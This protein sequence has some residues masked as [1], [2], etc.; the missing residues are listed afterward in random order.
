MDTTIRN[1][2]PET[3]R[4]LKA[5]A[6]SEGK[7][8]GEAVNEAMQVYLAHPGQTR[9]RGSLRDLTPEEYSR[10]S[11]RL[12]EEV[13]QIVYF[14]R[15]AAVRAAEEAL[16]ESTLLHMSPTG[17]NAFMKVLSGPATPVR[18][19]VEVLERAAPWESGGRR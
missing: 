1:L 5:R 8:L 18:E 19:F 10:E 9:K 7:T 2:D 17:F 16:M 12:S 4:Q 6:A 14:V 13:D 15:E 11:E 3:Y